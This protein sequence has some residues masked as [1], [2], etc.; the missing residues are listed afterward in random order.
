MNASDVMTRPAT[1]LR[2]DA[3]LGEAI[4]LMLGRGISGLPIVDQHGSLVGVL[5]EGDLLRRVE[6]GTGDR[7]RSGWRT[8]LRGPALNAEE[9][10]RTHSRRVEDLMTRDPVTVTEC[11]LPGPGWASVA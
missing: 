9:Y 4:R 1:T 8:F 7:H 6:A 3:S 2:A 11:L 10:V 5:T